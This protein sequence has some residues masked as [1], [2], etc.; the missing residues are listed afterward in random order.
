M[1]LSNFREM[2]WIFAPVVL[3]I[4]GAFWATY[5]FVEPA[6]PK[7]I[8]ISTGGT[9][10]AYYAFGRQYAAI[11]KRSG[12][13]LIVEP[14]AGSLENIER[15]RQKNSNVDLALV[16]GGISNA[17]SSPE[18]MSLGRIFLEPLWVFYR[19]GQ[20]IE[21]LTDLKGRR[22][23]IGAK[24]SGTRHLASTLLQANGVTPDNAQLL[25]LGGQN[26]IKALEKNAI[27][28]VFLVL[29]PQSKLIKKLLRNKELHLMN[30]GRAKAYT[31]N[32]PYLSNIELP[33]GTVDF[34][35]D[36][37]QRDIS[38]LAAS[39]ALVAQK[40]LHPALAG[41]LIQ[42][43]KEVHGKGGIFQRIGEFPKSSD[44]E[45]PI[46][47][48]TLR[49]YES[50]IPFLQRYLPFWLA[51]FI[52]RKMVL[53]VPLA[54]VLLPLLKFAPF[55]YKWRMRR[56]FLHW[57]VQLKK[58]EQR[59]NEDANRGQI[60]SHRDELERIEKAVRLITVPTGFSD[61]LYELKS[62]VSLVRERLAARVKKL[63]MS[64]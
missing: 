23:A 1:S 45:Y 28:A 24:N 50:G 20:P 26:A 16:Q 46:T 51:S 52:Q 33:Q 4:A 18:L 12:I 32:F 21:K 29:A 49:S 47:T 5:Q 15:L 55:L 38:L 57:Y 48:D 9:S 25:A 30:F 41:L 40:K 6:P 11:L 61:Q 62:A 42:A 8:T 17:A 34:V 64:F 58:L 10:G 31:R 27:D 37:P 3:I 56:R 22:I 60:Q 39:A 13:T 53:L 19:Q 63:N 14:S 36:I 2:I 35:E 54:T 7:T 44:P 43:M 59:I